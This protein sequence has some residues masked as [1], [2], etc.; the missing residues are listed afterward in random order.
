M[1]FDCNVSLH[2]VRLFMLTIWPSRV[3]LHLV[4]KSCLIFA[5]RRPYPQRMPLNV[6]LSAVL[7]KHI[8]S[9]NYRDVLHA[10]CIFKYVDNYKY[11]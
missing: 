2:I 9:A 10:L 11:L 7:N 4:Y 1:A 6:M 5:Q 8:P 3:H